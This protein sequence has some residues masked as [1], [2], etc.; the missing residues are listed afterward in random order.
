MKIYQRILIKLGSFTNGRTRV[1]LYRKAGMKI[2]DN[3]QI[4]SGIHVDR[5][6]GVT[7]GNNCF[8]NHFVHFHNGANPE[9]TIKIGNNVFLGPEVKFICASHEIGDSNKRAG[10]NKYGAI[11]VEDGAWI[12][13]CT[14]L[15]PGVL[16]PQ[17]G[18]IGA[19]SV[20]TKSSD[21]NAMYYGVPA[22]KV[23]ELD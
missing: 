9:A 11:N 15:L 6:E 23:R 10:K 13:A 2:G 7:I 14:I 4:A 22:R 8:I 16:I 1:L 5:P 17:G 12:G 18:V 3:V 20:V 19:G 21:P